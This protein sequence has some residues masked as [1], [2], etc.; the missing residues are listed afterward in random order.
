MNVKS[1]IFK[2]CFIIV[3]LVVLTVSASSQASWPEQAKLIASDAAEDDEF[4]KAVSISGD[5]AIVGA[6]FDDANGTNSGSVYFFKRDPNSG[7]WIEQSE[8]TASDTAAGDRFGIS[9]S[10]SG[11]TAIVGAYYDDDAGYGSGSAYIFQW[12]AA[13]WVEQGK[14]TASDAASSDLF[15]I[16]VSIDANIAIVG[17]RGDDDRGESSGAAYVYVK[18]LSGWEDDNTETVKLRASDG[19]AGDQFGHSVAVSG[20]KVIVGAYSD[21]DPVNGSGSGSAYIFQEGAPWLQ[22]AKLTASDADAFDNFGSSVAMDTNTAIVG[23]WGN[24]DTGTNS[25]S[26]YIFQKPGAS[27]VDSTESAKIVASDATEGIAFGYSVGISSNLAIVGAHARESGCAYV[28]RRNGFEWN[29]QLK[30]T[31]SVNGFLGDHFG[32]SV[33]IDQDTV[34]AGANID[35]NLGEIAS[36]SAY[37]YQQSC[38]S[39]DL[40]DDC[41]VNLPDFA[42]LANQWMQSGSADFDD[43][44]T[45]DF[46]DLA[47]MV[48]QWL[49]Q[50]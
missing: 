27:W 40:T 6:P 25:G 33:S 45:V 2:K 12:N 13:N 20:N 42:I 28:F 43:S 30:L 35:T 41:G 9:V 47:D 5:W 49:W 7:I 18:P 11:V 15:G 36:G 10:I 50:W 22:K 17:A 24:D 31:D 21:D 16:S 4:G 1:N 3:L 38:P 8:L 39:T 32:F 23:A 26:A 29:E 44:G 34:I 14:L 48:E 19:L 37:I 46:N